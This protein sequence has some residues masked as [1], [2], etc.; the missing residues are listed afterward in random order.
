MASSD[1]IW[2]KKLSKEEYRV[3]REK[4]TEKVYTFIKKRTSLKRRIK[5]SFN[6]NINFL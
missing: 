6:N 5:L 4:G 3:T 2:K 1:D